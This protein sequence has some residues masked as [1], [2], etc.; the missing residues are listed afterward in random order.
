[1]PKFITG[2]S[3][4]VLETGELFFDLLCITNRQDFPSETF[5]LSRKTAERI[6]EILTEALEETKTLSNVD[7][8]EKK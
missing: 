8:T 6:L 3:I 7:I 1:M 5:F 4:G 2:A